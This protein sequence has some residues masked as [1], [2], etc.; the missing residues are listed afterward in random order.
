MVQV[1]SKINRQFR[2]FEITISIGTERI[3]DY[4]NKGRPNTWKKYGPEVWRMVHEDDDTP[5]ETQEQTNRM[6][7]GKWDRWV[8]L[9]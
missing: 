9:Q 7:S 3:Y 5:G 2:I 1:H 8:T 6:W 4:L